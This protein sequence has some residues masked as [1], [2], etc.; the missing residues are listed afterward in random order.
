MIE[1]RPLTR[2]E[3]SEAIGLWRSCGLTRP[4]NDP[5]ADAERA[6]K[7]R[8]STIIGALASGHLIGTAMTGWDGHRGWVYYLAVEDNFRRWDLDRNLIR[9]CEDWLGQY[10][11]PKIQLMVGPEND[12]A[13]GFYKPI[14]YG[15]E[16]LRVFPAALQCAPD[17]QRARGRFAGF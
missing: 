4:W 15:E 3:V 1:V 12:E 8:F 17:A 10:D 9:A 7:G 2:S 5:A 6:L 11:P 16:T 13:A 14:G